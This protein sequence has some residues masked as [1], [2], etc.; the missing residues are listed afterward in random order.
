MIVLQR[1]IVYTALQGA[2]KWDL[3]VVRVAGQGRQLLVGVPEWVW[4]RVQL[5]LLGLLLVIILVLVMVIIGFL[6][7]K[8][9]LVS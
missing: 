1:L 5:G 9:A 8:K 4:V 3:L 6:V 7:E 2:D